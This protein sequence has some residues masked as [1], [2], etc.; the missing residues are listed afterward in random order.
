[1]K[2]KKIDIGRVTGMSSYEL[3]LKHGFVGTEEEFVQKENSVYND[4]KDYAD[5]SKAE[6]NRILAGVTDNSS[7]LAEV[8]SSRGSFDSLASRLDSGD[9]EIQTI[10]DRL[11]DIDLSNS[12]VHITDAVVDDNGYLVL[13]VEDAYDKN[14]YGNIE[15]R[16]TGTQIQW[17][18]TGFNTWQPL[19]KLKDLMPK[20]VGVNIE[21]IAHDE[22]P[23]AK[24][25]GLGENQTLTLKIPR[26]EDGVNGG[27]ILDGKVNDK[28]ELILT[29]SN[30][31]YAVLNGTTLGA[32]PML[33]VGTV[34]TVNYDEDASAS[35]TGSPTNPV[36]NLKIP[37][38]KPTKLNNARVG[39]NGFLEFDY[40]E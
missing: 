36:L 38:G 7:D 25:E 2:T 3:A 10:L 18:S 19:V 37:R 5:E 22:T 29:V 15:L 30:V 4:M 9:A 39:S 21:S 12:Q 23:E 32:Y 33:S 20:I 17:R 11:Q 6:L 16:N 1:M 8:V 40:V 31:D 28:G 24:F 34:E 14:V 26:G 27:Q 35:I 13:V